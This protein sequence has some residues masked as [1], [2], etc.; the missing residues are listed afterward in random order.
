MSESV[1]S[2]FSIFA[3]FLYNPVSSQC[4][5]SVFLSLTFNL[6]LINFFF[7][8]NMT[9]AFTPH[10]P[11]FHLGPSLNLLVHSILRIGCNF[12]MDTSQSWCTKLLSYQAPHLYLS[13]KMQSCM[14][15]RFQT[16][17]HWD[18][19]FSSCQFSHKSINPYNCHKI[20]R[21]SRWILWSHSGCWYIP[22]E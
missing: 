12:F 16:I 9:A 19:S 13:R 2:L 15:N 4:L 6:N 18:K 22:K 14:R 1:F 10:L 3:I 8:S 20:S 21:G 7:F 17:S 11:L 5:L